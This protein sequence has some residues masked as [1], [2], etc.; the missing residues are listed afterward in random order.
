MSSSAGMNTEQTLA[1]GPRGAVLDTLVVDR[2]PVLPKNARPKTAAEELCILLVE[3]SEPSV[4]LIQQTLLESG[5]KFSMDTV[6]TREG[7]EAALSRRAPGIILSDYWMPTFDGGTALK[8]AKQVAPDVPFIFVTGGLGEEVVIEMLKQG[9][10]DY[11]L[12]TRLSRLVPAVNRALRETGQ[13]RDRLEAEEKFRRSHDQ[14]RALTGRLQLVR[15]EERT[16]IA[17]EVHD[18]L[19]QALTGLKLDLSWIS[20]R[21]AG[22]TGIHRMI[23]AMS[24]QLDATILTVRRIATELRPGVL[25]SLGLAAAIEWQA[26]DFQSRT[27]ILCEVTIDVKEAVWDRELS[28]ACFRAFQE[29]LTNIIRHASATLVDVRLTQV[30]HEL[31]LTVRDNGRGISEKEVA[32]AQSIGIIG[33]RERMAQVG[34]EVQFAGLPDKGTTVTLRVPMPEAVAEILGG[35]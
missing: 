13:R 34:G 11:V 9:A 29:T 8:I 10:T 7:F 5:L 14:L 35:A 16:R 19:G 32:D 31:I 20:G 3:D 26:M 24:A 27:S 17:R 4:V 28:T 25:D 1:E 21:L 33:M 30:G 18:E 22:E 15:E 6:D 23:R 12:K 2:Q